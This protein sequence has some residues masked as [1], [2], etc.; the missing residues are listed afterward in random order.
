MLTAVKVAGKKLFGKV[1]LEVRKARPGG[2][3]VD[4]ASL[5]G[6]LRQLSSLGFTPRTVIDVGW[7]PKPRSFTRNSRNPIFC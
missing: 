5:R 4:R 2:T 1:G 6:A 7:L 3:G